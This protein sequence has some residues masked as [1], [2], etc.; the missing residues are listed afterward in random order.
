MHVALDGEKQMVQSLRSLSWM[1]VYA[2]NVNKKVCC[3]TNKPLEYGLFRRLSGKRAVYGSFVGAIWKGIL[4][5]HSLYDCTRF[6]F[7]LSFFF[8]AALL[9][10]IF[11]GPRSVPS[12]LWSNSNVKFYDTCTNRRDV[13]TKFDLF[14][15]NSAV[16]N[17][18]SSDHSFVYS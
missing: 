17:Y 7:L 2:W 3:G 15:S 18:P 14:A 11:L 1:S 8:L 16:S 13:S 9:C 6:F 12:N 10:F 4:E 5:R